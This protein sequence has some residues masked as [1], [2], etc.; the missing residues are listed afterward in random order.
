M[1]FAV[2]SRGI[3]ADRA[4]TMRHA[5]LVATDV[6]K[7]VKLTGNMI[8]GLC[9]A[10]DSV[11]GIVQDVKPDV[12]SVLIQGVVELPFSG[13]APVPG[14]GQLAADGAG[15]V[16]TALADNTGFRNFI[17]LEVQATTVIFILKH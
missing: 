9:A 1:S 6:G 12:C 3:V 13:A 11:F 17:I 2:S 14:F 10:D 16:K 8:V 15:A 5:G 7:P 4:V